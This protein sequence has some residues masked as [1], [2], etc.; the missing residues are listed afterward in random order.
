MICRANSRIDR[1]MREI[2]YDNVS[3][4]VEMSRAETMCT[5]PRCFFAFYKFVT[6]GWHTDKKTDRKTDKPIWKM[7]LASK[8]SFIELR[9]F[10]GLRWHIS[11][12]ES[13]FLS[14]KERRKFLRYF[15]ISNVS[16][17]VLSP[18]SRT[19]DLRFV[20]GGVWSHNNRDSQ[21][22]ESAV[23]SSHP[24]SF[25]SNNAPFFVRIT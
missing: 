6:E 15:V 19:G 23:M 2:L 1:K 7:L 5:F 13:A 20:V 22:D 9:D 8:N 25:S 18:A 24:F 11:W 3:E 4:N 12:D 21:N 14:W 16:V 10:E 17:F